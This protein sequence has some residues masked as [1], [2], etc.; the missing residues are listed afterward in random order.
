MKLS[1]L[2]A[3]AFASAFAT[4]G[5]MYEYSISI[6]EDFHASC[7]NVGEHC[8]G[9]RNCCS[10]LVCTGAPFK[11]TC[12]ESDIGCTREGRDCSGLTECCAGTS[13]KGDAFHRTCEY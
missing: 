9:F 13:C 4:A 2:T 5:P 6:E 8:S 11:R 10:P 12:E 7:Y 3:L 1:I